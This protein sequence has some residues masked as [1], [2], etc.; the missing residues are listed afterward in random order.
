MRSPRGLPRSFGVEEIF[1][2]KLE[3]IDCGHRTKRAGPAGGSPGR[4][5]A[6]MKKFSFSRNARL[7]CRKVFDFVFKEG[8]RSSTRDLVMW[9][10]TPNAKKA[11]AKPP[12]LIETGKKRLGLVISKKS[13]GAVRRNRLKRLLREAYRLSKD[14]LTDGAHIIVYPKAGCGIKNLLEARKALSAIWAR[15]K[16]KNA[17]R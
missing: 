8:E 3:A 11:G 17:E 15:A 9:A 12:G 6:K 13:G 5:P 16:I 2:G 4:G 10:Y 1:I 14:G 7:H